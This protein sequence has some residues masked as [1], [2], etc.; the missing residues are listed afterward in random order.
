MQTNTKEFWMNII[1]NLKPGVTEINLHAT[2]DSDEP[3]AI[4]GGMGKRAEEYHCFTHDPDIKKL[5]K[6][7]GIILIG[8]RPLRELQRKNRP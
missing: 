6:E 8:F 5:L 7:E 3:R 1:K 2:I 4:M